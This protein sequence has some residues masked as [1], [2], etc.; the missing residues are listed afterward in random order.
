MREDEPVDWISGARAA[1]ILGVSPATVLRSLRR[2]AAGDD[3]EWGEQGKGWRRKP[4]STRGAFQVNL[5]V[6]EQIASKS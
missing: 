4:L 3:T 1:A 5:A 2:A 6:A